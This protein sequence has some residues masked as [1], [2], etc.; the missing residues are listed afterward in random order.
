MDQTGIAPASWPE[1]QLRDSAR[2]ASADWAR[3]RKWTRTAPLDQA[4]IWLRNID[5]LRT[6]A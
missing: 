1:G 4:I 5:V 3:W 2:S 6:A